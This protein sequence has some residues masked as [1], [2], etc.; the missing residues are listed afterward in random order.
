MRWFDSARTRLR[1][2]FARRAADSRMNDEFR[3]HIEM[4]TEQLMRAKGLAPDEARRQALA[5]FG[6]VEKH[7]EALRDGRGLAWLSSLSLDLKLG[8]RMLVKYPGLTLAGGLALAIAIGIGAGWYDMMGKLLCADDPAARRRPHR[9]H[10]DAEYP[11]ERARAARRCATSSN[12][13]ASCARSRTWGRTATNVRNLI[14]GNAA[15]EL[16][17]VAE[18]TAAAFRTARV[19]S[20]CSVVAC[21]TPTRRRAHRAWSCS[22]TTCGSARSAAAT[23]S[24]D[25]I[26]ETGEHTGDRDWRHAG[27]VRVSRQPRRLDAAARFAPRTARSRA[28]RSASSAGW[29]L[30]SRW[31][32]R[33][34]SCA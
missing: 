13:G 20:R 7:K 31:S 29:R 18:L 27:R 14:V 26:G 6:G 34:P 10:R 22:A 32:R 28:V 8:G 4:E 2:L 12:G 24:S 3:F 5:A 33:T 11:D 19:R 23:T 25:S 30:A 1:L 15:P 17:Q 21:S 16:I 9:L